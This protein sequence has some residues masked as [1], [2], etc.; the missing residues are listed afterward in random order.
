MDGEADLAA[1]PLI[2]I[3]MAGEEAFGL[4]RGRIAKAIDVMWRCARRG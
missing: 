4:G 3:G 2:E 1:A